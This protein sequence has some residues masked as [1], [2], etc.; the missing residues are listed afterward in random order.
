MLVHA[1]AH[2][3][4]VPHASLLA[5]CEEEEP[6]QSRTSETALAHAAVGTHS[7]PFFQVVSQLKGLAN[8]CAEVLEQIRLLVCVI[9]LHSGVLTSLVELCKHSLLVQGSDVHGLVP[10][11]AAVLQEVYALHPE[12]R[13]SIVRDVFGVLGR[14]PTHGRHVRTYRISNASDEG[15]IQVR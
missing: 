13:E 7:P 3:R 6:E 14:L 5:G 1:V 9:K 15:K 10:R 2:A 11:C 4:V 12:L 8:C